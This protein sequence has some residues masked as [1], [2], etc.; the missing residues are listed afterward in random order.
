MESE[1]ERDSPVALE[2]DDP[3][4][5]TYTVSAL[6]AVVASR[7]IGDREAAAV[8]DRFG[9]LPWAKVNGASVVAQVAF[10]ARRWVRECNAEPGCRRHE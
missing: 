9:K 3:L 2:P 7:C 5:R 1:R 8:G 4:A 10:D 6:Q